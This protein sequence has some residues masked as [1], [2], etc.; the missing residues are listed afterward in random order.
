[1]LDIGTG[2]GAIA[3]SLVQEGPFRRVVATDASEPALELARE[4]ARRTGLADAV[5]L[6]A[7]RVWEPVAA[8]ERFDAVVSNPPYVA[9]SERETLPPEVREWEPAEALFA[10]DRGLRVLDEIV[11]GAGAH[12]EPGGLLAL[13][14]GLGQAREVAARIEAAGGYEEVRVQRDL[15]DRERIVLARREETESNEHPDETEGDG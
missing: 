7:G 11:A 1:A 15:A 5:E 12:L 14:V 10:A 2:T 4:N 3:L 6:R 8:G 9:E 13:E